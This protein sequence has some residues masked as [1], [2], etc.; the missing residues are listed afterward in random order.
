MHQSIEMEKI[1]ERTLRKVRMQN[2]A[3][4][5]QSHALLQITVRYHPFEVQQVKGIVLQLSVISYLRHLHL[6]ISISINF[7]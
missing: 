1:I 6:N 2:F 4:T 7:N 5:H 3:T